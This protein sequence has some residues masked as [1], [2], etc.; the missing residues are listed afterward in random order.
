MSF[1][2]REK[3]MRKRRIKRK[4][5]ILRRLNKLKIGFYRK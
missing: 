4:L 1:F 5:K 2:V 3:Q